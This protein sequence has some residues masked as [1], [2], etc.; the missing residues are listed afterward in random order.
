MQI[1]SS[2]KVQMVLAC[3]HKPWDPNQRYP[4]RVHSSTG[5]LL[6]QRMP[7][8]VGQARYDPKRTEHEE[9]SNLLRNEK[10]TTA[11]KSNVGKDELAKQ[12]SRAA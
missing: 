1:D 11:A 6:I 12:G 2:T 3:Q 7:Q 5:L 10:K 9:R 8:W 4:C